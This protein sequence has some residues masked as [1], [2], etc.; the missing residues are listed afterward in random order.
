[1]AKKKV[2]MQDIADEVE[3]SKN[4]VSRAL[5]N[6][7]G[8]SDELRA[9]IKSVARKLGY[10]LKDK[11]K[12]KIAVLI[13]EKYFLEPTFYAK[14]LAGIENRV[15]Q[16]KIEISLTAVE[17]ESEADPHLPYNLEEAKIDGIITIGK[18]EK[19]FL[20]FLK[21]RDFPVVLADYYE[22]DV[23]IDGVV[24]DNERGIYLG[25]EHLRELGHKEI[26]FV[27]NIDYFPC[28]K[29]RYNKYRIMLCREGL[30]YKE[31]YNLIEGDKPFWDY[32]YLE[33]RIKEL[34][35]LPTAWVCTNDRTAIPLIKVMKNLGY[36]VPGD[37]SIIG[38]DNVNKSHAIHPSLTTI[39]VPKQALGKRAV[40]KLLW[41]FKNSDY[42]VETT[43]V[44]TSLVVRDSTAQAAN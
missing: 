41:R 21:E 14:I 43:F 44:N 20:N 11:Q 28:F 37:S 8:V 35:T 40:D 7:E 15:R 9:K 1:M 16:N 10:K 17:P 31:E 22:D 39:H 23:E 3:V 36:E 42:P 32:K 4:T 26:G 19:K 24:M 5:N 12:I 25:L 38:F 6:K 29:H 27:G 30:K 33:Q 34:S 18:L 2:T 13:K